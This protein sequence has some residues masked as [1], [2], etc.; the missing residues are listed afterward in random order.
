MQLNGV[1]ANDEVITK[2]FRHSGEVCFDIC[3]RYLKNDTANQLAIVR[4]RCFYTLDA[5]S[6]LIW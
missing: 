2:F 5:Y 4:Q 6:K 3:H 1:I